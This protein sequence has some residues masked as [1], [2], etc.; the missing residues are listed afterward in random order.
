LAPSS[1]SPLDGQW[2]S[3]RP[4]CQA[5]AIGDTRETLEIELVERLPFLDQLRLEAAKAEVL[6]EDG[7]D[8]AYPGCRW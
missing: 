1:G 8:V 7:E 3:E 4:H 5:S 2:R 6:D